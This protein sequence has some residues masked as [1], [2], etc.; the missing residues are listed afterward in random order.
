MKT[1]HII[2]TVLLSLIVVSGLWAQDKYE[3]GVLR[4]DFRNGNDT[5]QTYIPKNVIKATKPF[6]EHGSF[7]TGMGN[8]KILISEI[9]RYQSLGWEVYNIYKEDGKM[10]YALRRKK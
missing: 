1:N 4:F 7:T 8:Q 6:K 5:L 3:Y 9:E 10:N 2:L